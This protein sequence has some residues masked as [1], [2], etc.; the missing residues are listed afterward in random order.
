GRAARGRIEGHAPGR[1][2]DRPALPAVARAPGARAALRPLVRGA[3]DARGDRRRG[4]RDPRASAPDRVAHAVQA[5]GLARGAEAQGRGRV[6]LTRAER[7]FAFSVRRA[8]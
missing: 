8:G 4:G 1:P 5:E 7:T 3:Y 6:A 2:R